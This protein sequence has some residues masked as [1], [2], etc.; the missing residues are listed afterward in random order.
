MHPLTVT[1]R[2]VIL[3][4]PKNFYSGST[5]FLPRE[6]GAWSLALEP[7]ALGL[8]VAPSAAGGALTAAALAGFFARR[9]LRAL[10][11]G[12]T[13]PDRNLT[14]FTLGLLT[15]LVMIGL[16][17]L[18]LISGFTAAGPLLL[19]VPCGALFI[20]FDHHHESRAAAAE[21]AG[22]ATFA[23]LPAA[24]ARAAGWSAP[25]AWALAALALARSLPTVLT[26]RT[27]L[28]LEKNQGA[29][30]R[31]PLLAGVIAL[32]VIAGLAREQLV[33]GLAVSFLALLLIRTFWLT[34]VWRPHLSAKQIGVNEASLG[35]LY[36]GVLAYAYHQQ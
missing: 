4:S 7:L 9:P 25:T 26:I 18:K 12:E 21:L 6:H 10:L 3:A 8:L 32:G 20:Y 22:C 24:L 23:I 11:R 33:P 36:L 1:Q 30:R 28:R 5:L 14:R 17:E 35:L 2:P 29:S 34:S 27:Y 19:A 13:S 15:L 31:Q 16:I